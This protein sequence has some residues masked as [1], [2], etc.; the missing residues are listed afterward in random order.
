MRFSM[1]EEKD[2]IN[3]NESKTS[4]YEFY[5]KSVQWFREKI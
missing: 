3:L 1:S 4:I 5:E 2:I